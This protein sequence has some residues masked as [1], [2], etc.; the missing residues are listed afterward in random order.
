MSAIPLPRILNG[1]KS[2]DELEKEQFEKQMV[3]VNENK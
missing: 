2:S 1:K 3:S